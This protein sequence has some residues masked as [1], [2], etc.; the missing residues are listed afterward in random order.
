MERYTGRICCIVTTYCIIVC[1][2]PE[3]AQL[4]TLCERALAEGAK[5]ILVDNTEAPYLEADK[6]PDGCSL[7]SLG[8]NSGIAHGQNV[9]VV[10]ALAAGA[11]IL[12]FFDQDTKVEAGLFSSLVRSLSPGIPEIVSP[13]CVDDAS[14]SAEP[15]ARVN[16]YGFSTKVHH[17]DALTRYPVDIVISSGTAA[18]REVFSIAGTF[19]E[20]FFIDFVD[21]EW[22]LR[23]RSK[24]IPIYVVPSAVMRHNIG[25]RHVRLGPFTILVHS[26]TRCYYQIRNCFLLFRRS[27]VPLVWAL[28][29]LVSVIFSRILLLFFVKPRSSYLKSYLFGVRDGLKGV[30]GAAP[31]ASRTTIS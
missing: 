24:N 23:C 25:S 8:F 6:L 5:V 22:C 14:N 17:A 4:M 30:G 11:D 3:L 26:S 27:H 9:G 31:T 20:A 16:R 29:Q 15:A 13:L 18:T 7:I 2:R 21:T 10:E 19:D 12:L 1:Y 28:R